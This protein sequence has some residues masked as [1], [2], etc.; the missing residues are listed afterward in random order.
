MSD[1]I[2][3]KRTFT[4]VV[5]DEKE[6]ET[7]EVKQE[8]S[9][10]NTPV[11]LSGFSYEQCLAFVLILMK[12]KEIATR[13]WTTPMVI[14]GAAGAGKTYLIQRVCEVFDGC[15]TTCAT[16]GAAAVLIGNGCRIVNSLF[17]V[18]LANRLLD[19]VLQIVAGR[20]QD[21][22]DRIKNIKILFWDEISMAN[23]TLMDLTAG[24]ARVSVRLLMCHLV[25]HCGSFAATFCNSLLSSHPNSARSGR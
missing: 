15:V 23:A 21:F 25:V 18:G 20:D 9:D 17:G 19:D 16:S 14:H 10:E 12:I 7:V 13:G 5:E 3:K 8:K 2:A 4:Q 24:V 11:D 6:V 1:R 22:K